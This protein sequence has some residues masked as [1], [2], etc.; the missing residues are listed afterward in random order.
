MDYSQLIAMRPQPENRML[1]QAWEHTAV[2]HAIL[3]GEWDQYAEDRMADFFAPEVRALLPSPETSGNP[4]LSLVLQMSMLYDEEPTT[5]VYADRTLTVPMPDE[6]TDRLL[7]PMQWAT[8]QDVLEAVNGLNDCMVMTGFSSSGMYWLI[9]RPH[10]YEEEPDPDQPDQ[11]IRVRHLQLT[12][13][14]G[15]SSVMEWTWTTWD[16]RDPSAFRVEAVRRS[17]SGADYLEDVTE[18][19]WPR[20]PGAPDNYPFRRRDGTPI[21]TWTAY[22]RKIGRKIRSPFLGREVFSGTL[23][24]AALQTYLIAGMRDG[25]HPQRFGV[26]V[27]AQIAGIQDTGNGA[28]ARVVR[29]NQLGVMMFTSVKD[30]SGRLDQFQPGMDPKT[31]GEAVA[32][33]GASLA[34]YAGI[35]PQDV[36]ISGGQAG[37]SGYAIA[38][39][40]DG[41]RR[42][43]RKLA[44]PMA[45]GDRIRLSQQAALINAYDPGPML[46]PEDPDAYVVKFADLD[47]SPV[48][49]EAD[50][51]ETIELLDAGIIGRVDAYMRYCPDVTRQQA[52]QAILQQVAENAQIRAAQAQAESLVAA[53]PGAVSPPQVMPESVQTVAEGVATVEV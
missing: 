11:P 38:I 18:A 31:F 40:R 9:A 26:D 22:H 50:R 23:T 43:R 30:G 4:A 8:M 28:G 12:P 2:R 15:D 5:T 27:E 46:L 3:S 51:K 52:L 33:F 47:E 19:Y 1:R 39:S 37:Q 16:R 32:A 20:Q 24:Y 17:E 36:S 42:I 44:L 41:Q 7:V 10:E 6:V 34:V 21:W 25:A 14:P 49:R 35:A 13:R 53:Q 48:E 45:H 29:M